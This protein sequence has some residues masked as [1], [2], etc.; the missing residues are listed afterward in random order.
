MATKARPTPTLER[1]LLRKSIGSSSAGHRRCADCERSPLPG[2]RVYVYETGRCVCELCRA[3]RAEEPV[4]SERV[5]GS[6]HGHAVR[7]TVRPLAA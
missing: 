7:L 4:R 3:L 5:Y 6:E 1:E 2:E